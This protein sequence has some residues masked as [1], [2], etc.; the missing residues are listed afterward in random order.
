MLAVLI[1]RTLDRLFLENMEMLGESELC[2]QPDLS[3][4][5]IQSGGITPCF[6]PI[7]VV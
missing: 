2:K 1:R 7:I 4:A 3:S 5:N 6:E